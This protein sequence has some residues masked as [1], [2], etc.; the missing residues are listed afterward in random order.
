MYFDVFIICYISDQPQTVVV[1]GCISV[2]MAPVYNYP[3]FVMGPQTVLMERM[4]LTVVRI[5]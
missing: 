1:G 3:G 4:K 5:S 2:Q